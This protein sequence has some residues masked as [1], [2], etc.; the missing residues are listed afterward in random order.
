MELCAYREEDGPL[1]AALSYDTVHTVNA[2]DYTPN[3]L[4]PGPRTGET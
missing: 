2:G 4:P 3:S 1:L